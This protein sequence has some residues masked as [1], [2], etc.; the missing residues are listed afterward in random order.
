MHTVA[1]TNLRAVL[2]LGIAVA[3]SSAAT[4]PDFSGKWTLDNS[5]SQGVNGESIEL[6]IQQTTGGKMDY[7]R[8]LR[9]RDGKQIQMTF[10]CAADGTTCDVDENGHTA[11]VTLW[12][13]GSA[14][15]MAKTNGESHDS[16]TERTLPLSPDGKTLIIEFTNYSGSGKPEKLVFS[17]Q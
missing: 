13:D 11:K 10:T 3:M 7:K 12:Y 17:K 2:I 15:V 4:P 14:L 16:T 8:I 6:T 1:N 9:E 5:R